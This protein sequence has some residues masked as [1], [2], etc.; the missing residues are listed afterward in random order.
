MPPRR[1]E[2][3][4]NLFPLVPQRADLTS[5][6]TELRV[7]IARAM[8]QAMK[9]STHDRY[10]IAARMSR[11]L[12]RDVSKHMLDAYAAASRETHIPNLEFCIAFDSATEQ[13]E[14]LNLHAALLGCS[15]L[16]GADTLHA[17]LVRLNV[18]EQQI[19]K[20]KRDLQAYLAKRKA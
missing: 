13:H 17:E 15:V 7:K 19:R 10:E 4:G 2:Q 6:A 1:D 11:I 14:L 20:R 3:S 5:P 16:V 18:E 9:C 12:G 8:S